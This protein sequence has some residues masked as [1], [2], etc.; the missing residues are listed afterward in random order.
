[1]KM[2][3]SFALAFLFMTSPALWAQAVIPVAYGSGPYASAINPQ[4]NIA[5]VVNRYTNSIVTI[6]LSKNTANTAFQLD[7]DTDTTKRGLGPISVAINPNTNQAVITNFDSSNITVVSLA[8]PAK[9]T[10]VGVVAVDKNPRAVAIDTKRNVAIVANLT[11]NSV[12][13]VDLNTLKNLLA[14][15]IIVGTAPIAVAYLP[16]V[17][18]AVVVNRVGTTSG[19]TTL[20]SVTLIDLANKVKLLDFPY[21]GFLQPTSIAVD[22]EKK[23]F[24]VT[25]SQ[26]ASS[27]VSVIDY[28]SWPS[29]SGVSDVNLGM[30]PTSVDINPIN[31][32]AAVLSSES[33]TIA[34]VD[35]SDKTNIFRMSTTSA[36]L[37][38][39]TTQITVN[40]T[41]NTAIIC[42][43]TKDSI[44]VVSMGYQQNIPWVVDSEAFRSN[45][46][47]NNLGEKSS[48]VQIQLRDKSGTL[49]GSGSVSIASKGMLQL[50]N[51]VRYLLGSE[52]LTNVQGSLSLTS[53]Q[54][55]ACFA[56][57]IDN[58]SNDPS[59]EIGRTAGFNRLLINSI[60]NVGAY[61]SQVVIFNPG[62]VSASV[63][64][65]LRSNDKGEV[66]ATDS[67]ILIPAGGFFIADD[68]ISYLKLTISTYGPLEI[69]DANN[70]AILS[71]SRV[72]SGS[73]TSG[74]LEATPIQ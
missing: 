3:L 48:T 26:L 19:T 42:S 5:V 38:D 24:V 52:G 70:N 30:R 2:K 28:S 6:D 72:W 15:P 25:N 44:Y 47:I 46:G 55:F 53:D 27:T 23:L 49:I 39:G 68:M 12:S 63:T 20:E 64:L 33:K 74:F 29:L 35:L 9:P 10:I 69:S 62:T 32:R 57:V 14:T 67:T 54:S 4:T 11:A 50:N 34:Y 40:S 1:M 58:V 71:V 45:L 41:N 61:H 65:T 66:L 17:D 16:D 36:N 51:V 56:S 37:G 21:L 22:V 18:G 59:I 31:H 7:S 60:T 73:N 43:P 8:D 13:L